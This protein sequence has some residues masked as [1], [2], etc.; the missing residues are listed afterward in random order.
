MNALKTATIGLL[1][2]ILPG[3]VRRS[4]FHLSFHLARDE[5]ERFAH[6]YSFAPSMQH[7]LAAMAG[8]GF[9][10]AT[11]IDVGAYEGNW[12]RLARRVWPDCALVM[13]EANRVKK[14]ALQRVASEL[15]ATLHCELLGADEG[16]EVAFHVME[17]GSSVFAECSPIGRDTE[18]RRLRRLD[19]LLGELLAPVFLKIDAQGYELQILEGAAH[20][21]AQAEVVLLEVALIEINEGAPLLHDVVGFM[22]SRGFVAYDIVEFHRRPLDRALCQVDIVFVREASPLIADKRH[23]A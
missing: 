4:M 20:T 22:K 7:G 10:P 16:C 15:G 12:S 8:R 2:R 3:G 23:F 5:Y 19:G 17:S 13:V 1:G 18:A 14:V 9:D 21:L 11:V 6:A